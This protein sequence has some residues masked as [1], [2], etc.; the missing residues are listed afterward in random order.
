[1]PRPSKEFQLF[2]ELTDRLLTVPRETIQRRL[3]EYREKAKQNPRRRGP[4]PKRKT[5]EPSASGRGED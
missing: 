4:K 2:R 5:T 1:M 3:D